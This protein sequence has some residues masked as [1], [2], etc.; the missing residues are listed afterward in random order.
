MAHNILWFAKVEQVEDGQKD[1][2]VPLD[3]EMNNLPEK[4]Q[5]LEQAIQKQFSSQEKSFFKIESDFFEKVTSISGLLQPSMTKDEKKEI[6]KENL[7][8]LNKE[9]P[10]NVYLPT[11]PNCRVTGIVT[12]SGMPMQSAARVPIMVSFEVED[13]VGPDSDPAVCL[14]QFSFTLDRESAR[15]N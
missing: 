2:K 6:I 4:A 12:T 9:V 8:R 5:V 1:R 14:N 11:N 10:D 3:V 13:Y 7:I 15:K